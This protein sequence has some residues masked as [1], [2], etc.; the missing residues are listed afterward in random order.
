[1]I[2]A[3]RDERGDHGLLVALCAREQRRLLA[4][5]R[6]APLPEPD[7]RDMK[8]GTLSGQVVLVPLRPFLVGNALEDSFVDQPA[9][10]VGE[11][12]PRDPEI[13]LELVESTQSQQRVPNDQQRPSLTDHLESACDRTVLAFVGALEHASQD[14]PVGL[15]K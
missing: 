8:V 6:V 12:L 1:M 11:N 4:A 5:V 3:L 14:T 15:V 13:S 10:T 7:K 2:T 9:K